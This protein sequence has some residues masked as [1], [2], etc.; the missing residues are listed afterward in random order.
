MDF[1]IAAFQ[2]FAY[3]ILYFPVRFLF[4]A[5]FLYKCDTQIFSRGVI[6]TPNHQS[7][8]DIFLV[9][10]TLIQSKTTTALKK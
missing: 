8:L 1:V 7:R 5:K 4:R 3:A 9:F 6:L 2:I 10:T